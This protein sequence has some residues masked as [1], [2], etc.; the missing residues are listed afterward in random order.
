MTS[1]QGSSCHDKGRAFVSWLRDIS[2][3]FWASQGFDRSKGQFHERLDWFGRPISDAPHRLMLQARQIFVCAYGARLGWLS[4]GGDVAVTAMDYV[5]RRHSGR[6]IANEGFAFSV[7]RNGEVID[8][9]RDAYGHAFVLF[10]LAA[11]FRLTGDRR[12]LA[13]ADET[14]VFIE[15]RLTDHGHGGVWNSSPISDRKKKQNPQMHLLEAYLALEEASP[16]R[17]YQER[18]QALTDLF[19]V[20]MYRSSSSILP[21]DFEETWDDH[22]DAAKRD[23]F[24]PGHHFEWVWLLRESERLTGQRHD[25]WIKG[26]GRIAR[27]SGHGPDGF[28]YDWVRIDR[29]PAAVSTRLWPHTEAIKA[30]AVEWRSGDRRELSR[31]EAMIDAL[32]RRFLARPFDAGWIDHFDA[33]GRPL[34][35]YVPA[36]SLYHI[37]MAA[38]EVVRSVL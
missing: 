4:D 33:A 22:V 6:S 31:C 24:E 5:L 23:V 19:R 10:A 37:V 25:A 29:S 2:L 7:D 18:A 21:E 30:A 9:R 28:I 38:G 34:V 15:R 27:A 26:L 14:A 12:W 17:G 20:R 3:P 16:G 13:T 11:L 35:D 1:D 8:A 32:M 36:S